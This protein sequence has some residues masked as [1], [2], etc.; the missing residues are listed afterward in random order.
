LF[1]NRSYRLGARP[2]VDD[3]RECREQAA[4]EVA[5][6]CMRRFRSGGLSSNSTNEQAWQLSRLSA[7]VEGAQSDDP[8]PAQ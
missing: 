2:P 4:Q 8:L 1:L 7:S 5:A 3:E 6:V